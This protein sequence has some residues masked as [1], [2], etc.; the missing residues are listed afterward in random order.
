MCLVYETNRFYFVFILIFTQTFDES[1][2]VARV[3]RGNW[4]FWLAKIPC[5]TL[6]VI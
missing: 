4:V 3:N 1:S 6:K 2:R 5:G